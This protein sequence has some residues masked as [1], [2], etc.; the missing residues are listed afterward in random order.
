MSRIRGRDT[1]PE[2]ALRRFLHARGLRFRLH[3]RVAG[4]R[5]DLVFPGRR[6]AIEVHGCFWHRHPDP[7]CHLTRSPKSKGNF[8][9][10][11]F[12]ENIARDVR[13]RAALAAAGWHL[14]EVWECQVR[15]ADRLAAV[16]DAIRALPLVCRSRKARHRS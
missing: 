8:W 13:N 2:L 11:K 16:A 1:S 14:F 4:A 6:A 12:A 9:E 3:Q 10:A 15:D 5:P 7:S